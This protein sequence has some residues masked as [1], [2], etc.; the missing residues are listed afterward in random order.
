[1]NYFLPSLVPAKLSS[2]WVWL[3]LFCFAV[4]RDFGVDIKTGLDKNQ[5]DVGGDIEVDVRRDVKIDFEGGMETFI[6]D[7]EIGF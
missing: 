7:F 6:G 5:T 3:S 1:M 4:D 2:F